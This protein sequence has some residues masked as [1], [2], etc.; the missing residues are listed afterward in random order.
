MS[1]QAAHKKSD[2][3]PRSFDVTSSTVALNVLGYREDDEDWVALALE[4]DLRGFGGS[5]GEALE[6]LKDLVATQIRFAQFKGQPELV[7]KPAEAIWF[8]RFADVRREHLNA[9]VL[10]REPA[11]PSYDVAGLMVPPSPTSPEPR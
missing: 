4:M 2:Q 1:L 9:L 3:P 5:F 11:D 6:E 8:E 10:H 7:W